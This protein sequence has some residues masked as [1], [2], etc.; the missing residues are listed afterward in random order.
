VRDQWCAAVGAVGDQSSAGASRQRACHGDGDAP[1]NGEQLD[2]KARAVKADHATTG[3]QR[4]AGS[5]VIPDRGRQG[6]TQ[7][8]TA[9]GTG[10]APRGVVPASQECVV[11]ARKIARTRVTRNGADGKRLDEKASRGIA[12]DQITPPRPVGG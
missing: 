9:T 5:D 6:D 12:G 10:K 3:E 8:G 4:S 7:A 11:I 2:R 1:V